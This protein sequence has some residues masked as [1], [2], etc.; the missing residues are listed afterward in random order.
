MPL[1]PPP[2]L[3]TDCE[4][5]LAA[6]GGERVVGLLVVRLENLRPTVLRMGYAAGSAMRE[7][8]GRR[9]V[10]SM[11]ARD[12]VVPLPEGGFAVLLPDLR[13][14]AQVQ[15]A[16]AKIARIAAE[17][18][19]LEQALVPLQVRIGAA[20]SATAAGSAEALLIAA[21]RALER[22]RRLGLPSALYAPEHVPADD[23]DLRIEAMLEDAVEQGEIQL[24]YQPKFAVADRSILGAEALA[25]WRSGELGQVSPAEFIAVAERSGHIDRLTWSAV[26]TVLEATLRLRR[27]GLDVPM[28]VNVSATCLR[29]EDFV[30]R[31][32]N[33]L[34]LW[35]VPA[36]TLTVEVTESA[37]MDEPE[38]VLRVLG[39]LR[40][41]GARIAIDDFGTGYSSFSYFKRL[42]ADELK[43]D[44]SFVKDLAS[45]AADQRIVATIIDLAHRFG[46]EV[47]AEGVEDEAT[48]EC[49]R[50]LGCETVQGFLLSKPVELAELERLATGVTAAA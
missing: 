46:M 44:R 18:A 7:E 12:Q 31:I 34:A 28:A 35:S 15:L 11:R 42:P 39:T 50:E 16:A 27:A 32:C 3:L 13:N 10:A 30:E 24:V 40:D 6:A 17:P 4:A 47:V 43:I 9:L 22:A 37:V 38:T 21:A 49:L 14:G 29:N 26:N 23:R 2:E 36:G 5:A 19:R 45:E 25:R 48:L 1:S 33:A 41:A 20:T 8:L